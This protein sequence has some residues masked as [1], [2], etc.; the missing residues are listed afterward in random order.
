M[1]GKVVL[2]EDRYWVEYVTEGEE[3]DSVDKKQMMIAFTEQYKTSPGEIVE[4][5]VSSHYT[6]SDSPL[7]IIIKK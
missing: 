4:F 5:E 3:L 7:A 2:K 6:I 1:K